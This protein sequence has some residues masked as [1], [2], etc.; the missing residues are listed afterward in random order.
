MRMEWRAQWS[1]AFPWFCLI[2]SF[3]LAAAATIENG[4]GQRGFSWVNGSDA[5]ATRA[6]LLSVLGIIIA[7]GII[8]EAFSRDRAAG[9]EELILV[10]GAD[11]LQ[12]GLGRFAAAFAVVLIVSAMFIPGMIAG[13]F[14]PG[15]PTERLGPFI[16]GHYLRAM[17]IYVAPNMLLVSALIYAVTARWQSQTAGFITALGLIAL[18][19]TVLM[20]LGRQVYRHDVFGLF[21]LLDPYGNIAG[22]EHSMTWTVAQNNTRFRPFTGL[23]A[24]NRMIWTGVALALIALGTLGLPRFLRLPRQRAPGRGGAARPLPAPFDNRILTLTVWELT[25]LRRQPGLLLLLGFAAFSLWWAAASAVTYSFSLPSTDLLIHNTG[26]YFDKVLVVLLVW[27]AADITWREK[28]FRVD[29]IID[30]TPGSDAARLLAKTFALMVVVLVFWSLSISVNLA[31]QIAQGFHDFQFGLYLADTF[32]IKAP[33]YLFMAV[34]AIAA[35][36][37]IRQRYIAMVLVLFIYL[38]GPLFDA[39]KLY[40]PIYRFGETGFFW[41]SPMD[42]YG[43]FLRGHLW[44]AAYWVLV[45]ALLWLLA[46]GCLAR[47]TQPAPRR[48]LWQA[49]LLRGR[50]GAVFGVTLIATLLTG[51]AILYQ[52][53]VLHRWPL[54]DEGRYMA[55]I[56]RDYRAGWADRPQP[57]I[58]GITGRIEIYPETR[59]AEMAGEIVVRN[60]SGAPIPELLV[61]FRPLLTTA[62]LDP[63]GAVQDAARSTPHVQV[64]T[65]DRPLQPGAEMT[66]PFRT[67]I[68]P[69]PGFAAHSAHDSIPEVQPVEII[70]NGTSILNLNLIPALGYSERLEHKPAWLRREYG[71]TSE[72]SPPPATLGRDVAHDTTHLAWVEDM[73]ITVGTSADQIPLHSGAMA[74]DLGVTDGRRH[75]RYRQTGP[76]RGWAEVMSGRYAIHRASRE[77]LPPVELYYHPPHDYT[78][79][80]MAGE[81]LD[82]MA[83]FRDRYGAP[84]FQTFRLAEASLHYTGFGARGGLG[85]VSEVI[86]WK[87]DLARSGGE[88]LRRNAGDL[89]GVSWWLDQIIP[90]NLPGA[91]VVLSGLPYWTSALYLHRARG[92]AQSREARLQDML[93]TFRHR[94][95][96]QDAERPFIEEMKDSAMIR[97]KGALHIV[98]LAELVG[99]D[100]LEAALAGFLRDWRFRPAPY[101]TAQDLLDHLRTEL[102]EA[103][104]ALDDFF[105]RI[106]NWQLRAVE[107]V[108]TPQPDGSWQLRATVEAVQT[109][110]LALGVEESVPVTS[111]VPVAAFR[112]DGFAAEELVATEW[113]QLP[114]GRSE[115][116]MT[117]SERPARFGI[118]PYLTLP[119]PNPHDNVTEVRIADEAR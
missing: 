88:D 50:G 48:R 11:R 30:A 62:R 20:L 44:F 109:R 38:S 73:D 7:A 42:G 95:A 66:L 101:P 119:D 97:M 3:L 104:P 117:L 64:W 49:R 32:L 76:S 57:K 83:Y 39:L 75:I 33:Y 26:Y 78:L 13:S 82:A 115:I 105:L 106:S 2:G 71:L 18:Y 1:R 102:P 92:P 90:A 46:W 40:H 68:Q 21:A 23:L 53:T 69:G 41:Y 14:A 74:E 9:T 4:Y 27:Y 25:A 112:G 118:D 114:T 116:T 15:I 29:E 47:G 87:T 67:A 85:F 61:F 86:G 34:L 19:A 108:A 22:A 31:Y 111:P 98:Y 45:S 56:E 89:I 84:P 43:H 81:L 16:P 12:R 72:W 51:A 99:Q 113:R 37:I 80:P 52:T 8:G 63:D 55:G 59:S 10:T 103:G 5:I 6:L 54:F 110:T 65:L 36:I 58:T 93:E 79:D 91:K 107:A 17:L 77:G 94:A 96:L 35:Q 60:Q 28:Q 100:R 24:L 70:G